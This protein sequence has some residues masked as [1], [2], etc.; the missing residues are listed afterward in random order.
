MAKH[1]FTNEERK[2]TQFVSGQRAV[3]LGRKGQ[4][5]SIESAKRNRQI[6]DYVREIMNGRPTD[7]NIATL[8]AMGVEDIEGITNT[9]LVAGAIVHQAMQGN[10]NAVEKLEQYAEREKIEERPFKL[11]AEAIGKDFVDINRHIEPNKKYIFKGGRGSLKSSYIGFKF[12]E[13]LKAHP[14]MH[15]IVIRKVGLTLKDSVYSQIVWCIE[16]LGIADEFEM[17]RSPLEIRVKKTGQR[18]YFRGADKP[19]KIKSIK[20]PFGYIGIKWVEEADQLSGEAEERNISQSTLRGQGDE[21]YDILSYNPPK[22]KD[23]WLNKYSAE[24]NENVVVHE[25]SFL[26]APREWLG[27]MFLQ[28][29]EHLR[30]ANPEAYE[31]EYLGVANGA[32]GNVFTSVTFREITDEEISHFDN[33]VQGVDW[34]WIDAYAFERT[35]YDRDTETIYIFAEN[36][37]HET[38]NEQT[39]QWILDKGYDDFP[40]TCDSA[41]PKSINDYRDMGINAKGA[42]KGAGSINYGFKWLIARHIVVDEKRCPGI[43]AE[44]K[45]YEYERDKDGNIISGFPDGNDHGISALRYAY[46]RYFNKRG[47]SA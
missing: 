7:S 30:I 44:L 42:V 36:Y 45:T 46:E 33:I 29:A 6:K 35:Y 32:G 9:A 11:P 4:K 25:S 43:A 16:Y 18:I 12:L 39:G 37:V 38:P 27:E 24:P 26:D 20:P 23:N 2:G 5:K 22:S 31:N 14:M 28:E 15:G 3:E 17:L 47:Y 40:I 8:K 21:F 1:V 41:E 19:E 13:I 34:G 10:L